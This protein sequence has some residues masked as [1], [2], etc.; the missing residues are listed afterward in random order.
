MPGNLS[1]FPDQGT[2]MNKIV[3]PLRVA[4]CIVSFGILLS[5][6][7]PADAQ[8]S[9]LSASYSIVIHGGAGRPP[10]SEHRREQ[11]RRALEAAL[12]RG[13]T[14]L[15]RGESSLD[16]VETVIRQLEDSPFFNAGKGA[17]MNAEGDIEL[18]ASI[19]DG[20]D[21]LG[22]AVGGVRTVKNPIA[23]ARR[24][25]NDT[26]HVL[27]VS[28]G[29]ERFADELGADIARV[30]NEHFVTE[31]QSERLRRVQETAQPVES[32]GTVGCV[33]RDTHGNLAAGTSTG[34][35]VNKRFGRIGDTPILTAGTYADNETCA[36]SCTG[37]GEDFIRN[38]VAYDVAARMRYAA[39]SMDE[40]VDEI[41][42]TPDRQVRGGMIAIDHDGH[43]TMQFNTA[44]M[45][46]AAAD[47]QGQWVVE[48][49]K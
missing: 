26:R 24:V 46:R 17:V 40:A 16:V 7:G 33:A 1:R 20:R 41:L 8:D 34:G 35:L 9:N 19:M 12:T 3:E 30:K 13:K 28:D 23:L 42:H 21:R 39:Q 38:A 27:L 25:M 15:E 43:V 44:G 45:A 36:V 49:G 5:G 29:A 18:D 6:A 47:S 37:T 32:R 2:N 4:C 22:G 11:R 10:T 48:I 14:M 31:Y